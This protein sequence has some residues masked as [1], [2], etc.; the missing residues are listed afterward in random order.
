[1]RFEPTIAVLERAKTVR[2]LDRATTSIGSPLN[3]G[4]KQIQF[5]KRVFWY[6]EFRTK[7]KAQKPCNSECY[8]LSP[9]PFSYRGNCCG[10]F[11]CLRFISANQGSASLTICLARQTLPETRCVLIPGV[12]TPSRAW[13]VVTFSA[14]NRAAFCSQV[15]GSESSANGA[16]TEVGGDEIILRHSFVTLVKRYVHVKMNKRSRMEVL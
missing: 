1:V 16:V 12:T 2:A 5:P 9:E 13:S 15:Q 4:W 3:W 6:L 11:W 14:L 7:G 10:I 8:T